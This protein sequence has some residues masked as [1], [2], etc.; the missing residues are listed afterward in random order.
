MFIKQS[1]NQALINIIIL[2]M[3]KQYFKPDCRLRLSC[4][5]LCQNWLTFYMFCMVKKL[6]FLIKAFFILLC[7]S[8]WM[9]RTNI[10]N[11]W[12]IWYR[13]RWNVGLLIKSW[14]PGSNPGR[15]ARHR[16]ESE[17]LTNRA[18]SFFQKRF[19]L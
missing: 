8:Q 17:A 7:L 3:L 5:K 4:G 1:L 18:I 11:Q 6:F 13:T 15:P 10:H 2:V 14:R 19:I 12:L 9:Q 16:P